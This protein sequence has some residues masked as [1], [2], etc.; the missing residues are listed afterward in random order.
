MGTGTGNRVHSDI[1]VTGELCQESCWRLPP[2]GSAHPLCT[3][4]S[5][6]ETI[7]KYLLTHNHNSRSGDPRV[8]ENPGLTLYH[9]IWHRE[10]N[11]SQL[12]IYSAAVQ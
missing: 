1:M 12:A 5:G 6:Q 2:A 10:H 11:R 4:A 7:Y 9:T 8:N 3:S